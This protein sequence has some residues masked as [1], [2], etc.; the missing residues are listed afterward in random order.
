MLQDIKLRIAGNNRHF[1]SYD[2]EAKAVKA[3]RIA[4]KVLKKYNCSKSMSPDEIDNIVKL[5]R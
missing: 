5:V 2:S 1:G 4:K 3:K